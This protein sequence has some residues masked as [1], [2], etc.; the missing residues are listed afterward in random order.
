MNTAF[1]LTLTCLCALG[2]GTFLS[3]QM[4]GDTQGSFTRADTLRGSIGPERAWWDVTYYDVSL[5]PD[6]DRH[7]IQG[8]TAIA[9]TA[10]A[11]G[12]RMQ[13]DLQQPLVADSV[14]WEVQ[15]FRDSAIV[16]A[17]RALA[18]VREG[19]VLWVDLPDSLRAGEANTLRIHYHGTPRAARNPPW[20]GGWIW[21][22]DAGGAPW[23]SVACQGLG[24]SVWYPCKD[25]QSDEPDDGAALH[26]TVPDSLQA[27]GNGRLRGTTPHGDGTTT[28]HWYV[29]SP[30][31]TYN[32]VP[33]IGRYTHFGETVAG[34]EGPLDCDYWVLMGNEDKARA[35]FKQVGP[36]IACFEHWFGPYPFRADGYK[37]VEAP[38][39]GMEH[40][41]AVAYGNDYR[42]GYLGRDLSGTGVGLHWDFILVHESGHEWFGNSITTADIADMWVHEGFTNYS[43][44]LFTECQQG[45]EA[46]ERYVTGCRRNI[47]NDVPIIGPYGVNRVGSGDMYYKGAALLHMVRHITGDSTF[48]AMLLEMNRRFRHR[49]T[50]SAEVEAFLLGFDERTRTLL[51]RNLF[52]QYLRTVLVPELQWSVRRGTLLARWA[53]AVPGLRMSVRLH[54]ADGSV[55]T[56][57]VNDRWAPVGTVRKR[58]GVSA[59]DPA[60]YVTLRHVKRARP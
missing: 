26:I 24:A 11:G 8:S 55:R 13:I 31:N 10:V 54:L 37:L 38:H 28:W 3:A 40:Q 16:L 2:P 32:L 49:I 14:T 1:R 5:R 43:E 46:A 59:V 9:F 58:A 12:R 17:D 18:F 35:Q 33:Y 39:L 4:L 30:I 45:R 42:N 22:R 56:V 21:R 48:R 23:A 41:S 52:D 47:T 34:L 29:T 20:D 27:V 50:G 6:L 60:W 51:D 25:H 19:D 15:V 53:N 57:V 7:S 44:T 36:M